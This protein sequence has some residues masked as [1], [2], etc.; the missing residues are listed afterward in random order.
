M[1]RRVTGGGA[2]RRRL[3]AVIEVRAPSRV[4]IGGCFSVARR[5][6]E[7]ACRKHLTLRDDRR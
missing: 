3:A 4:T 1:L 2:G 6:R 5:P 7:S